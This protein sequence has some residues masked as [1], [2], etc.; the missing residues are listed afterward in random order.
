MTVDNLLKQCRDIISA[1]VGSLQF[2]ATE[3]MKRKACYDAAI[4]MDKLNAELART[5]GQPSEGLV[6]IND[7]MPGTAAGKLLCA[8]AIMR[9]E[10]D[11][12]IA[13]AEKAEAEVLEWKANHRNTVRQHAAAVWDIDTVKAERDALKAA[14]MNMIANAGDEKDGGSAAQYIIRDALRRCG[15]YDALLGEKGGG[16]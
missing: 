5:D 10:R 1:C 3:D 7:A 4:L 12:A 16:E 15:M 6:N 11:A 9:R 8:N 2:I 13:R 14:A